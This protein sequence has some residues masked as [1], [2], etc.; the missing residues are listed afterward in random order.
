VIR[1]IHP[2]LTV[3]DDLAAFTVLA[4]DL[5]ASA[6]AHWDAIAERRRWGRV[7]GG[8]GRGATGG[9]LRRSLEHWIVVAPRGR[10]A[11]RSR[12]KGRKHGWKVRI[13]KRGRHDRRSRRHAPRSS[14]AHVRTIGGL[15]ISQITEENSPFG[16]AYETN[17][18]VGKQRMGPVTIEGDFDTAATIGSHAVFGTLETTPSD[19][20]R[21]LDVSPDGTKH[22]RAR[23]TSP[24]TSWC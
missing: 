18:P 16:V 13:R 15:K 3:D 22:S 20:T 4:T 24:S 14:P 23:A 12:G 21:T 6:R 1:G 7:S 10:N 8:D 17:T 5:E 19:A 2:E 11:P 9:A